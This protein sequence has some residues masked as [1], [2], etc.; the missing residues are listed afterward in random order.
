MIPVLLYVN[1]SVALT[2]NCVALR[3]DCADLIKVNIPLLFS[4][5]CAA[6]K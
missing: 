3:E 4:E 2:G 5:N 6:L 1:I